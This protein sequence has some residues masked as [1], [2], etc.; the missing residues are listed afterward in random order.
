MLT[1]D[2]SLWEE[3]R[4][5]RIH[6][7]SWK[8]TQPWTRLN[9]LRKELVKGLHLMTKWW[10]HSFCPLSSASLDANCCGDGVHSMRQFLQT[11]IDRPWSCWQ[12]EAAY[13]I[14]H[15]WVVGP[16]IMRTWV[17][18]SVLIRKKLDS[19]GIYWKLTMCQILCQDILYALFYS[20]FPISFEKCIIMLPRSSQV[21]RE[22]SSQPCNIHS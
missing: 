11:E 4:R 2:P 14:P 3:E 16:S 12:Q 13:F 22:V 8:A 19:T 17:A 21:Y 1:R 5:Y 18:I 9:Q 20:I 7:R 6:S 15:I 10:W